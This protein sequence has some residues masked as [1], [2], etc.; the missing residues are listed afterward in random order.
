MIAHPDNRP[1]NA[2][3]AEKNGEGAEKTV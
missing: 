1:F 3:N 2:E